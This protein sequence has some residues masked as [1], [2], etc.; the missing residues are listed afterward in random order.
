MDFLS[1]KSALFLLLISISNHNDRLKKHFICN[2]IF[3]KLKKM[4]YI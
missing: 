1:F 4:M 2:Y 3:K